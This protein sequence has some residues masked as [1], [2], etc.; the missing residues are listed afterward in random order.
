MLQ[1]MILRIMINLADKLQKSMNSHLIRKAFSFTKPVLKPYINMDIL[2]PILPVIY[3]FIRG[4]HTT[5]NT[6]L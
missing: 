1:D 3:T 5:N 2:L 4:I 6:F